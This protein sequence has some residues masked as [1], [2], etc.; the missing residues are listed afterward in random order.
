[1][2]GGRWLRS[3]P[4]QA[5]AIAPLCALL[6]LSPTMSARC[7][8]AACA[9]SPMGVWVPSDTQLQPSRASRASTMS[10]PSPCISC[11]SVVSTTL[12]AGGG[13]GGTSEAIAC[14]KTP[15][16]TSVYRCSSNTSKR[17]CA[18]NSPTAVVSGA[19]S[20]VTKPA[21]PMRDWARLRQCLSWAG[22]CAAMALSMGA[23][24]SESAA[25]SEFVLDKSLPGEVSARAS[26]AC[27]PSR[28]TPIS[29][30]GRSPVSMSRRIRVSCR[31]WS[32]G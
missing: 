31:T 4:R 14:L 6:K 28:S 8:R 3:S 22:S 18:Q 15:V 23:K 25:F 24:R 30:L 10:R 26:S 29:L 1:M 2:A 11:G 16:S 12:G 20:V 27:R 9:T 17:P 7:A 21:R 32:A 13:E 5:C 19:T